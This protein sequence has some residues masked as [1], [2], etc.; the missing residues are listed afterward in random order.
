MLPNGL[1]LSYE[2][3]RPESPDNLNLNILPGDSGR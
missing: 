2:R 1:E 3:G